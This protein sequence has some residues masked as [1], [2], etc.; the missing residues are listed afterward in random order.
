MTATASASA[1]GSS[2]G[3]MR[4]LTPPLS[5]RPGHYHRFVL[6][7]ALAL[8]AAQAG[9]HGFTA[10]LPVALA[11]AGFGDAQIGFI[12]GTAALVQMPAALVAGVAIDR[13]G[14]LRLFATGAAAYASG[15][16]V[17]LLTGVEP[18][19][20]VA[21][22]LGARVLQGIGIAIVIPS[23]L[24]LVP[25]LVAPK[26]Q[27]FGLAFMGSAHNLTMG[28]LPPVSLVILAASSMRGVAAFVLA[29]I[30]LGVFLAAGIRGRLAE[31]AHAEMAVTG[32][33]PG[34]AARAAV[35]PATRRFGL[36]YRGAW[37]SPLVLTVLFAAHWG[38]IVAFLPQR[39]EA[40]GADI[41]LFFAA[42]AL[43]IFAS[44]VPTGWLAD[45]VPTRWLLLVGVVITVA[46]LALLLPRPT[47]EWLVLAGVGTGV[48]GGFV[49]S[50]L[51]LEF[52]RRSD[53]AD[54]GSAFALFSVA[55][56]A[57]LS[58]GSIGGAPLV[59]QVGFEPT[60]AV[61]MAAL[62]LSGVLAVA[63]PSMRPRG[64]RP[65]PH[66]AFVG[67]TVDSPGMVEIPPA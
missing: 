39:A 47:T 45:R 23:A 32:R 22:M 44:R 59:A 31:A 28:V 53:A 63:D 48:G 54:R 6:R 43:A 67:P 50:P 14:G 11:R 26:R 40:A 30:A 25:L 10:S 17:V 62:A 57:A 27:G 24:A 55:F 18:T 41:G 4:A 65:E 64:G 13:F 61:G 8:F 12:V 34:A 56:A 38:T 35:R 66:E 36:V 33:D 5:A 60:L 20:P 42:D 19:T 1:V 9:F 3:T 16:L 29:A 58:L 49:V 7:L 15:A 21:A 2:A 52:A 46:S 51:L 37:T